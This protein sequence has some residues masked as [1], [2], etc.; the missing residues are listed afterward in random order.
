M[1]MRWWN[2]LSEMAGSK[3]A[4]HILEV[5][6]AVLGNGVGSITRFG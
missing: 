3:E 5:L 4:T 2:S 1:R 6:K